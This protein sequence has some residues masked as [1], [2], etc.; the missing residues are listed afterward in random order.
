MSK[1]NQ[2]IVIITLIIL[3][4]TALN[5]LS[6]N[7]YYFWDNIQQVSKEAHWYYLTNFKSLLMPA[8]NSGAEIVATGYHPPL[9]GIIT[10]ALWKVFGYH[11]WVSHVFSLC[12]FFVLIY[13][14]RE[15]ANRLFNHNLAPW[16]LAIVLLE[17]TLLTQFIIASPDFILFTAFIISLRAILERKSILLTIGIFFLCTINMRGIFVGSALFISHLYYI[18]SD[19]QSL[20][21]SYLKALIPYLPTFVILLTYFSYY[22]ISRGWFFS[23]SSYSEHYGL[24]NSPFRIIKHIA[25]FGLRSIENGRILT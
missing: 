15:T 12:W 13:N 1:N 21:K 7:F 23:N 14:L 24:P 22:L 17:P 3:V 9:M 5:I 11:L 19:K 18:Y 4:Y 25:E 8:Q 20:S 16:V 6:L 10:A 2:P